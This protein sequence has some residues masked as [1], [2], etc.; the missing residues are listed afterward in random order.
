[1]RDSPVALGRAEAALSRMQG[2]VWILSAVVL[3][4]ASAA[5]GKQA[6]LWSA[7]RDLFAVVINPWYGASILALVLQAVVWIAALRRL[8]LSFAYPFMSLV[9]PLNLVTAWYCFDEQ[10][11]FNHLAGVGLICAGIVVVAR[12][13]AEAE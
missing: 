10:V 5:L 2:I 12:C 8:P 11:S 13:S 6:G 3:Q 7:Q 1:M 4:S 9:L